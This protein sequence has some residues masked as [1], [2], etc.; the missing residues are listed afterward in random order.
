MSAASRWLNW[1]P[2]QGE[3]IETSPKMEPTKPSKLSFVGFDG[4]V[5]GENPII[6]R[7]EPAGADP[8]PDCPYPLPEG[9]ALVRY[10]P[11]DPPVAVTVCSVVTDV[12]KFIRHALGELD[13]RL[14]SPI[15]IKA[16]DSVFELLSKLADCGLELHLEWP[17]ENNLDAYTELTKLTKLTKPDSEGQIIWNSPETEPTKPTKLPDLP[18]VNPHGAEITD[19]DV[20]F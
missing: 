5:S 2:G 9:V 18:E 17:P 12:P 14:H 15:Q 16:G 6:Q 11:K 10:T 7:L 3:I 20:P 4:S 13:A 19:E 1:T 8:K